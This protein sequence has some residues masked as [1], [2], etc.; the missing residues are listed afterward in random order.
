MTGPN[1]PTLQDVWR[2][3]WRENSKTLIM[4]T[5]LTETGKVISPLCLRQDADKAFNIKYVITDL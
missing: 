1:T 3:V 5:N 4:L 2:M